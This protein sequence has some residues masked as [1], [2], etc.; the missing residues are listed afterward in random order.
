MR[1]ALLS[2]VGR[3]MRC[4]IVG[5]PWGQFQGLSSCGRGTIPTTYERQTKGSSKTNPA[6][7]EAVDG[8][9]PEEQKALKGPCR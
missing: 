9:P 8:H 1:V 6:E 7:R 5:R 4:L 3:T 2:S